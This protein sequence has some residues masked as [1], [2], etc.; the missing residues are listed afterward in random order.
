GRR[1]RGDQHARLLLQAPE[2][3]RLAY[4]AAEPGPGGLPPGRGGQAAAGDPPLFP[5]GRG[6][7]RP[8]AGREP[9]HLWAGHPDG[10]VILWE[11]LKHEET[12]PALE[13]VTL[14]NEESKILR[15]CPCQSLG[16]T[17]R[18][19]PTASSVRCAPAS[20]SG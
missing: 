9:R 1:L 17:L 13:P 12:K 14:P 6:E 4:S 2:P 5:A 8:G 7:H 15:R 20:G 10:P 18:L 11:D 3:A 16:R 19:Q